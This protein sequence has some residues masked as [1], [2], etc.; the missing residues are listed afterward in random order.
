MPPV[1]LAAHLSRAR[2]VQLVALRLLQSVSGTQAQPDSRGYQT[3]G[4]RARMN[5]VGGSRTGAG[6]DLGCQRA[7]AGQRSAGHRLAAGELGAASD[8]SIGVSGIH[9]RIRDVAAMNIH[10]L[11]KHVV[12]RSFVSGVARFILQGE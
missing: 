9:F 6:T 1:D 7:L 2:S 4:Y 8:P 11:E 5:T 12:S 3:G 10:I